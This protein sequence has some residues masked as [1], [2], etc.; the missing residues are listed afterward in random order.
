MK[1]LLKHKMGCLNINH[2]QINHLMIRTFTYYDIPQ[3]I[4]RE[5]YKTIQ[6]AFVKFAY[7][8]ILIIIL[9]HS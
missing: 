8:I 3:I 4:I 5:Y 9:K 6:E 1:H 7:T 2:S